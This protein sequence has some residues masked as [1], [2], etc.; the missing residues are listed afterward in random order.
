GV[1]NDSGRAVVVPQYPFAMI[2]QT[3]FLKFI[4]KDT[5]RLVDLRSIKKASL[6]LVSDFVNDKTIFCFEQDGKRCGIANRRGA[7]LVN[8][9]YHEIVPTYSNTFIMKDHRGAGLMDTA[10]NFV[11]PMGYKEIKTAEDI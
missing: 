1:M 7:V 3:Y 10:G 9:L 8:P 5:L 6:A 4:H 2:E 11:L